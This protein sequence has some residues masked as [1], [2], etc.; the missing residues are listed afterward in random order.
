MANS[1]LHLRIL[2]RKPFV[3][4]HLASVCCRAPQ[5]GIPLANSGGSALREQRAPWM[6]EFEK[7]DVF[8]V[9]LC[10]SVGAW[11]RSSEVIR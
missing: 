1:F 5:V 6:Y 3:V 4:W 2:N 9:V 8:M 7:D 10:A 11:L